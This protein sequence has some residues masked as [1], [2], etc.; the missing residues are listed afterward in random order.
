MPAAAAR[1]AISASVP[2]TMRSSSQDAR[3]TTAAGVDS[4][5][6]ALEDAGFLP[7]SSATS[8]GRRPALRKKASVAPVRAKAAA[9]SPAG[10]GVRPGVR[11]RTTLWLTPGRVSSRPSAAAA[12]NT[13]LTP[14]TM[15]APTPRSASAAIC[16]A[17]APYRQGSPVCRRITRF[18]ARAA[19][20]M[21]RICSSRSS[22]ALSRREQPGRQRRNRAGLTSE[23]A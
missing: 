15:T 3:Q 13:L 23:P 20:L 21:I 18:P 9:V 1:W 14:G 2:S 8:S 4:G 17:M 16:S 12:A 7:V 6:G 5:R 10:M 22:P 11:V 19:S